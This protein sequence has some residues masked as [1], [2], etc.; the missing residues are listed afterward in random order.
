MTVSRGL[1]RGVPAA[2]RPCQPGSE[3]G[4]HDPMATH[5]VSHHPSDCT[6]LRKVLFQSDRTRYLSV[7]DNVTVTGGGGFNPEKFIVSDAGDGKVHIENLYGKRPVARARYP[8][9]AP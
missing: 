1:T 6:P 8:S 7:D 5:A 2:A 9:T 4:E 3:R